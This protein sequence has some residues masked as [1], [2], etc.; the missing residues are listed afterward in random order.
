[1]AENQD[2][3]DAE[4]GTEPLDDLEA[5]FDEDNEEDEYKEGGEEEERRDAKAEE[6]LELFGD[7]DEEEGD[8][9]G[10]AADKSVASSSQ[11]LQGLQPRGRIHS[12][13]F[14]SNSVSEIFPTVQFDS[15]RLQRNCGA[16]RRR[17]S[18]CS[19]SWRP[20][21]KRPPRL[22]LPAWRSGQKRIGLSSN[23]ALPK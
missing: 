5:L 21:R 20:V 1:M 22:R 13:G 14:L 4:D 17:C 7:V 6:I 15:L 3:Q 2:G 12:Q 19:S 9:A 16:C 8:S 11:D 23:R 10:A 18:S